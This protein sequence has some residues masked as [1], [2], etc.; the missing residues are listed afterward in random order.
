MDEE[1]LELA[2]ETFLQNTQAIACIPSPDPEPLPERKTDIEWDGMSKAE[3][4]AWKYDLNCIHDR[5]ASE[6]S[7]RESV[8]RKFNLTDQVKGR[9]VYNVIK[10]DSRSRFLC[11]ARLEPARRQSCE[12]HYAFRG[13][14]ALG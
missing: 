13:W 5:N 11:D 1:A 10:C 12:R 3:R 7:K 4:A 14:S 2:R 6:V 9:D 8:I